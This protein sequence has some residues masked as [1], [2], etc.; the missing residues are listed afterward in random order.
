METIREDYVEKNVENIR[1]QHS[2]LTQTPEIGSTS[3]IG[4]QQGNTSGIGGQP[5]YSFLPSEYSFLPSY[6][7]P[8][9]REGVLREGSLRGD[10]K[11]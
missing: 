9:V 4:G 7:L 3:E 11:R 8:Q 6:L 10:R 2:T 1:I 5:E